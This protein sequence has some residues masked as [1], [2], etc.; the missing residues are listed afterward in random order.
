MTCYITL[1]VTVYVLYAKSILEQIKGFYQEPVVRNESTSQQPHFIVSTMT[2]QL[3]V[4]F[5]IYL[6]NGCKPPNVF[7]T[8]PFVAIEQITCRHVIN[9]VDVCVIVKVFRRLYMLRSK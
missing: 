7:C 9:L 6:F 2:Q 1:R 8:V 5:R 3:S 4:I